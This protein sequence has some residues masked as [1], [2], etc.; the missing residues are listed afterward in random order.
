MLYNT[1]QKWF[2]WHI[3]MCLLF[4]FN[5]NV[6]LYEGVRTKYNLNLISVED[7]LHPTI[8]FR[9]NTDVVFIN[10]KFDIQGYRSGQSVSYFSQQKVKF[11]LKH[12][13]FEKVHSVRLLWKVIVKKRSERDWNLAN[14]TLPHFALRNSTINLT[15]REKTSINSGEPM[16]TFDDQAMGKWASCEISSLKQLFWFPRWK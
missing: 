9:K 10:I 5:A 1:T 4:F 11:R 12:L 2:S 14:V 16:N 8:V 3:M 6:Q 7:T 13:T 15:I